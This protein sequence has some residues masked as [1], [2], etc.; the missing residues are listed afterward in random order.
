MKYLIVKGIAGIGDRL[1]T[2]SGAI[3]L[4]IKTKRLLIIEWNEG[5]F[6]NNKKTNAFYKYFKINY[7][8]KL[9]KHNYEFCTNI[10]DYEKLSV[11]PAQWKNNLDKTTYECTQHPLTWKLN[12]KYKGTSVCTNTVKDITDIIVYCNFAYN[13]K[14]NN[15]RKY[16]SVKSEY[17][18][19]ANEYIKNLN[20]SYTAVHVRYSDKK[21]DYSAVIKH[22]NNST[23]KLC[24][25]ATDNQTVIKDIRNKCKDKEIK[26]YNKFMGQSG[27]S[28][29]HG[30]KSILSDRERL[31][32]DIITEWYILINSDE[33]ICS[34]KSCFVFYIM[35]HRTKKNIILY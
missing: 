19:P 27:K 3:Y 16:I 21:I 23:N 17:L 32:N 26:T 5:L 25:I 33:L 20:A 6:N 15:V 28:L 7:D 18:E 2:L 13:P 24:F 9:I 31:M 4:A 1:Q 29:H 34:V 11:W 10:P 30:T 12:D 22:I 14:I 35:A 8:D